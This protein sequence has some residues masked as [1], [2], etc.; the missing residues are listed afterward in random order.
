M[1]SSNSPN[2]LS[3]RK[4]LPLPSRSRNRQT[5]KSRQSS[6]PR[7]SSSGEVDEHAAT[8]EC[9][10]D[11]P[12]AAGHRIERSNSPKSQV[13][14]VSDTTLFASRVRKESAVIPKTLERE[15]SQDTP[16]RNAN[17]KPVATPDHELP[18]PLHTLV[19]EEKITISNGSENLPEVVEDS[20]YRFSSDGIEVRGTSPQIS[21]SRRSSEG[22]SADS[23]SSTEDAKYTVE[24]EEAPVEPYFTKEFQSILG[25]SYDIAIQVADELEKLEKVFGGDVNFRRLLNDSKGLSKRDISSTR[26]I[27]ILGASGEGKSSLINSLLHMTEL[28]RTSD[29]GSACTSVVT[30]YRQK[31]NSTLE[32][33]SIEVE[34]L[35]T[36]ERQEMVEELLWSYRQLFFPDSDNE[37]NA[38]DSD[39]KERT[40]RESA[41]AWSALEALFSQQEEFDVSFL[42]DKSKGSFER[43]KS[44]LLEWMQKI[45]FP[46]DDESGLW[47]ASAH[48]SDECQELTSVFMEDK[49]WPFT[50]IIRVYLDAEVLKTGVVLA[51]LP[52][53]VRA[54]QK[55]LQSCDHVFIATKISRA[56]TDTTLKSALYSELK[57][58]VP[59]AWEES[60]G[61]NINF[62]LAVICTRS[63]DINPKTA[64]RTFVGN[65]KEISLIDM[66]SIDK[67]IENAKRKG[68]KSLKE[69]LERKKL[70]LF[71]EA[72][73]RHV[74]KGLQAA[75]RQKTINGHLDVFCISNTTYEEYVEDKDNEMIQKS[76]IPELRRFCR[77]ITASAQLLQA[78][79]FMRSRLPS[80]LNSITLWLDSVQ[81]VSQV[82][83]DGRG[84]LVLDC[85][86]RSRKEATES[87]TK[88][89]REFRNALQ[90]DMLGFFNRE[91]IQWEVAAKKRAEE[92]AEWHHQSY[93]AWCRNN[94]EHTTV[95]RGYKNWNAEILERM[96][97]ELETK[98]DLLEEKIP[99][100]LESLLQEVK[101][102]LQ[103][104]ETH[105]EGQGRSAPTQYG[106]DFRIQDLEYNFGLI[107]QEFER[108]LRTIRQH[109][110]DPNASSFVVAEMMSAYRKAGSEG[111]KGMKVRQI[112][113][114]TNQVNGGTMFPNISAKMRQEAVTLIDYEFNKL[115]LEL[116][117]TFNLIHKDI[118]MA[119]AKRPQSQQ[120]AA[121]TEGKDLVVRLAKRLNNLRLKYHEILR[122][123][124][125]EVGAAIRGLW[126]KLRSMKIPRNQ[127]LIET[128]A[129]GTTSFSIN[130]RDERHITLDESDS[131]R[132]DRP[133]LERYQL[134]RDAAIGGHSYDFAELY[135]EH[136]EWQEQAKKVNQRLNEYIWQTTNL[137]E[138][139][140]LM[141][142]T[143]A[144]IKL[145]ESLIRERD[146]RG[147][148]FEIAL[149]ARKL[150][151]E[152]DAELMESD[153]SSLDTPVEEEPRTNIATA[154]M[155][156]WFQTISEL[157]E[158]DRQTVA[159]IHDAYHAV[160]N[161]EYPNIR[162]ALEDAVSL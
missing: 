145:V 57:R 158:E 34:Y 51:D 13:G 112:S 101:D 122:D 89:H 31:K 20:H 41:V 88:Y 136:R 9:S 1:T 63:D 124:E 138:D 104:L 66:N 99:I 94:G 17:L 110:E 86:E 59:L 2:L 52:A 3:P 37:G 35:S 98:W 133:G 46:A 147:I 11:E 12:T 47:T 161:G 26:T 7:S 155:V 100:N 137:R 154:D 8:P 73:N 107:Q 82:Q 44:K 142:E 113:I 151:D 65:G 139:T 62:K 45:E 29:E 132:T 39:E 50:K 157:W 10:E 159:S 74:T 42:S 15:Q 68:D 60:G 32:P 33:F 58:H 153:I 81:A 162:E 93:N 76:G 144:L 128:L 150:A 152:E 141:D 19:T 117:E 119:I 28:A 54:T 120:S 131:L 140:K 111:G 92:W 127:L 130:A 6:D 109:V 70:W 77:K 75:Y 69:T 134:N 79:H 18:Q 106:I 24:D 114:I 61:T 27:A 22:T 36:P 84:T 14:P 103:N 30:E 149:H 4:I 71:I 25:R 53:R 96:R 126:R 118:D 80:L 48:T 102:Q 49:L 87:I 90:K 55:Y 121:T 146:E 85:Y 5:S 156:E 116:H 43:I 78:L 72:R 64:K 129:P 23:E 108:G 105:I 125:S 115:K 148:K 40:E 91:S 83:D 67:D 38:L 97:V 56:I 160:R 123:Q 143:H 95:A 135:M 21:H 16:T